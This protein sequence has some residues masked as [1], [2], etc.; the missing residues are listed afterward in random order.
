L[1]KSLGGGRIMGENNFERASLLK[2]GFDIKIK[3]RK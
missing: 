3:G 1:K 2:K